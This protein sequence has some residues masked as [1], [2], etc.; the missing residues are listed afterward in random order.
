MGNHP[1]LE[2]E[3][4]QM[5]AEVPHIT[6]SADAQKLMLVLRLAQAGGFENVEALVSD[7][8]DAAA[9][10]GNREAFEAVHQIELPRPPR[11][12]SLLSAAPIGAGLLGLGILIGVLTS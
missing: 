1:P 10:G 5:L 8:I 3:L 6:S 2:K 7:R 12:I 9:R 4:L 11:K